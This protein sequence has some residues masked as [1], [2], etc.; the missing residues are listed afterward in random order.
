MAMS[1]RIPAEGTP[2]YVDYLLDSYEAEIRLSERYDIALDSV[3]F[4]RGMLL[5]A[6]QQAMERKGSD[7]RDEA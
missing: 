2:E 3:D 7:A 1:E 4:Y 6:Y 5:A